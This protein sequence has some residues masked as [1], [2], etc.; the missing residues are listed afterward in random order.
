MQKLIDLNYSWHR[1]YYKKIKGY[2]ACATEYF[3]TEDG[4]SKHRTIL[5]HTYLTNSKNKYVDHKNH[6]TLDNRKDNL[7]VTNNA[8]N[9][10]HRNGANKNNKTGVRNVH[11]VTRYGGKQ[12]YLVQ[13]MKNG[14]RY[15]WEFE[16]NEF[17][18]ACKYAENKRQEL[19]GEFA[20]GG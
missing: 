7:R 5:L 3:E 16:L 2:Y 10:Q 14:E 8:R 19:F 18:E 12:L 13:L 9:S 1:A 17:E 15:K 20:G 11:L 6:N 4:K